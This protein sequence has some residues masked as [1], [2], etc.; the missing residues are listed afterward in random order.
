MVDIF[1]GSRMFQGQCG[2]RGPR[3]I[4][5]QPG[6]IRDMCT[7]MPS[8]ILKN[9]QQNEETC[10][11]F[12]AADPSKDIKR[13]G[14]DIQ[15]WISRSS[16]KSNLIAEKPAKSL[17]ELP[18]G[19]HALEF[20]NARYINE[21]LLLIQNHPG[22]YGFICVTFRTSSDK[23]Q[24]LLSNFEDDTNQD[25]HEIATTTTTITISGKEKG[26]A[27]VVPIQ[28]SCRNWTTFFLEYTV[29][30]RQ[31]QFTYIINN[32]SKSTGDFTFDSVQEMT[33]GFAV[34]GRYNNT[35]FLQGEISSI[36]MYHVGTKNNQNPPHSLKDL[37][38]K[39]QLI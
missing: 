32:D 12:I 17:M 28:Y 2:S 26:I 21:D 39:N 35:H 6:S 15:K 23:E 3:G 10:C 9:I 13:T 16:K 14:T 5:G 31:T 7:W 27:K 4:T 19:R 8:T 30:G 37:V 18:N 11:F 25:F 34:G 36:E 33:T 20:K 1:G 24:I 38:I 22:S 29:L